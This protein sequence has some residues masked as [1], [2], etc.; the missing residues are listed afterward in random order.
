MQKCTEPVMKKPTLSIWQIW[1]MSFGFFGIQIGFALQGANVSRIFQSLGASIDALPILWIA[2]PVT[3][4]LVQPLVGHFSDKNWTRFGR[5]RPYFF[6]GA[7]LASL[8][9]LIMPNSPTLWIAAGMLW[10][11]DASINIAMEPFRAFVGDMLPSRQRTLG[12]TMQSVFIGSGALLASMA[13]FIL[14]NVFGVTNVAEGGGIPAAV[15]LSFYIGAAALFLAILWT[16]RSTREYSPDE[17]A[18]FD[19]E[20]TNFRPVDAKATIFTPEQSFF[21]KH[22]LWITLLGAALF[23]TIYKLEGDKQFYVLSGA[24]VFLGVSFLLNSWLKKRQH[25]DNFLSHILADLITMPLVMRRLAVVQFFSWFGL[26]IL[27]IYSTPAVTAHAFGSSDP[28]S[29]LY[30]QGADWVG[31]MFATYNGVAALYALILPKLVKHLGRRLLHAL[32]LLA[33]A[34]GFASYFVFTDPKML[35][36]SMVGVGMAWASILSLPYAMLSDAVPPKKLGI[37]MGIFNFFIVLP[38]LIVA[39]IM[40]PFARTFLGGD[41]LLIMLCGGVSLMLSALFVG[42]VRIPKGV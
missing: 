33:G 42:W 16:V 36:V 12:F 7:V 24:I 22:G 31:V 18:A 39:G 6:A 37:Y 40:G 11:L 15:K 20:Q 5:R 35:L 3:G 2:G 10:I 8:A 23:V 41:P 34:A 27:W 4:L 32:N 1:N 21:L 17:M 38:Q 29:V 28:A 25:D 30:N 9:L 26:F 14:T 13:P 19:A